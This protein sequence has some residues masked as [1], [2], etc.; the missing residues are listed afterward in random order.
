M[1]QD[2][3]NYLAL[4]TQSYFIMTQ[5]FVY[6]LRTMLFTFK[7]NCFI[8]ILRQEN[9]WGGKRNGLL[10]QLTIFYGKSSVASHRLIK[11]R[12]HFSEIVMVS[13]AVSKAGKTSVNFIDNTT[14]ELRNQDRCKLLRQNSAAAM[15]SP[16]DSSEV[17]RSFRVS[18]GRRA[19]SSSEVNCQVPAAYRVEFHR[20]VCMATQQHR[21]KSGWLCCLGSSAAERVSQIAFQFPT[22]TISR[23]R[24]QSAHLL[25]VLTNR[26]FIWRR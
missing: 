12:K 3:W 7:E 1:L 21:L 15:S 2:L 25:G 23:R 6:E 17:W 10:V 8:K 5:C 9:G 26:C 22:W 14:K 13:V 24:G 18:K 16:G 19:I 20:T 11:G 4:T